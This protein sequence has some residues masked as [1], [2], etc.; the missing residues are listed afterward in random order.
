VSGPATP[1]FS[2]FTVQYRAM[3]RVLCGESVAEALPREVD[4]VGAKRVLL[5][6]SAS[7]N[8]ETDVIRTVRDALGGRLAAY[9]EGMP[10][11]TPRD[12][13]LDA[14]QMARAARADLIVSLGGGSLTDA[15]KMVQVALAHDVEDVAGFDPWRTV[16]QADGATHRPDL[17]A[18]A[19]RMMSVP[20]TLSGGDFNPLAG[21][22]DPRH[23]VK[24][25]YTH[26]LMVPRA[27]LLDPAI[28]VHTPEWIWLSTGMR[29]VDH[30]V[31]GICS[32][33]STP[34]TEGAA[35]QALRLLHEGL[36][37]SK[38]DGQDLEARHLC[39]VGMWLSMANREANV[40]MGASH[41]IG[42]VLGGTCG[43]PHGYTSCVMLPQVLRYNL[44]G[45]E[46][47]A[48]A[49]RQAIV[50]E[51]LGR[52]GED[53]ATVVGELVA[54]LG[55]PTRLSQVGV[56]PERFGE[57]AEHAMHDRWIHTNPRP[58]TSPAQV[59]EILHM[60]E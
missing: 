11:H 57:V 60:A 44:G 51:A 10:P 26:P 37:R 38:A 19:V 4:R 53:A 21:C 49:R 9:Y 47:A 43:V 50:S 52:P 22:T 48:N 16:V 20:T 55:M 14:A 17:R 33:Q 30:A 39:Q 23:H 31:E 40:P 8:R 35:R 58:I 41:G 46:G 15:A 34:Y 7:L 3:E 6:G 28:T 12:A 25:S 54:A 13:V 5:M 29:A 1:P 36:T 42:H 24:Q 18:P 2:P 32:Q 27:V 59:L 56:A 45:A